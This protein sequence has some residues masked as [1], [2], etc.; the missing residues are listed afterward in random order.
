MCSLRNARNRPCTTRSIDRMLA[1]Q[2][3]GPVMYHCDEYHFESFYSLYIGSMIGHMP[4]CL[5][6]PTIC[7]TTIYWS[8]TFVYIP[9][10]RV[11]GFGVRVWYISFLY[12]LQYMK[13]QLGSFTWTRAT[14]PVLHTTRTCT[15][16]KLTHSSRDQK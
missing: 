13:P 9:A 6:V 10:V 14:Y 3:S 7:I 15:N 1:D 11:L 8:I 4:M 16:L 2:A 12:C 5:L